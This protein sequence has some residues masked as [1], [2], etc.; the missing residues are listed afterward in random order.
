[1][2]ITAPLEELES[3]VEGV[4]ICDGFSGVAD[5]DGKEVAEDGEDGQAAGILS[6]IVK[7]W[8]GVDASDEHEGMGEAGM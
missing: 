6:E 2:V 7:V 5:G 8:E 4:D 1:M 3:V